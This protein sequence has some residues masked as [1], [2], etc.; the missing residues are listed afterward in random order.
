[1]HASR[2]VF[3]GEHVDVLSFGSLT[4]GYDVLDFSLKVMG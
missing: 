3:R 2:L 4:H 1:M